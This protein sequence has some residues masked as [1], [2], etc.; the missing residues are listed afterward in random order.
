MNFTVRHGVTNVVIVRAAI[1]PLHCLHGGTKKEIGRLLRYT[2][3]GIQ[4]KN[5]NAVC[6]PNT[7]SPHAA[8]RN[9]YFVV[10]VGAPVNAPQFFIEKGS[11]QST[12]MLGK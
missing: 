4:K 1:L 9:C 8:L 7:T 3:T 11:E 6:E 2:S 12:S 10:V 5:P